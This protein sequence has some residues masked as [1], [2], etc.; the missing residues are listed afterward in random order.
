[1]CYVFTYCAKKTAENIN[2][3]LWPGINK[4][5]V[6]QVGGEK[7]EQNAWELE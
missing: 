4:N 3:K 6:S 5:A 2:Q 1:M 7:I